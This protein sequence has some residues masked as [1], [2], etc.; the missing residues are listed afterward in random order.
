MS[1]KL[2]ARERLFVA[3]DVA[4][5]DRARVLVAELGDTV[6]CYKVG[7]ELLFGGGLEFAQG[8]KAR[9]RSRRQPPISRASVST[10]SPSTARIRRPSLPPCAGAARAS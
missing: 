7:L 4:S 10:I 9:T 2:A 8:L 6:T 3:L 5:V 1:Q